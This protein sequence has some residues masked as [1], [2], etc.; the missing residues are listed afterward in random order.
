MKINNIHCFWHEE[1]LVTIT[2]KGWIWCHPRQK[3]DL[4]IRL[5]FFQNYIK[6]KSILFLEYVPTLYKNI[7]EI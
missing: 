5:L 2:N 7:N 4:K 3:K 1:D 6:Q